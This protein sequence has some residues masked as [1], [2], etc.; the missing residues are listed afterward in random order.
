MT[1]YPN[2]VSR[3]EFLTLDIPVAFVGGTLDIYTLGGVLVRKGVELNCELTGVSVAG[4]DAGIYLF[5]VTSVDGD[6][7]IV[8]VIVK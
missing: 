7:D 5:R 1:A 4:L 2:P 3:D 8:K 6:G